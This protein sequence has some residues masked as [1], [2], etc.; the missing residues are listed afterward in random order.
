MQLTSE[1]WKEVTF[2]QFPWE[3]EALAFVRGRLGDH[4]PYRAWSTFVFSPGSGPSDLPF[5]I[6]PIG[7]R[8][9]RMGV[10]HEH[11]R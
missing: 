5:L 3:R 9:E 6:A 4:D 7:L 1:R 11:A 10:H 8:S 2:S